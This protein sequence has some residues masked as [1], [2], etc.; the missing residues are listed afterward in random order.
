M[1]K[2]LGK[3][4]TAIC[5]LILIGVISCTSDEEITKDPASE[6]LVTEAK[7]F[8]N[9]NIVL[10]TH[11]TLNGVNKTLLK[12][13]CP[14]KFNFEWSETDDNTFTVSLLN[15]TVGKMGMIISFKCDVQTMQ[16]NT[17]EKDEY[18]GSGWFKFYGENGSTW[19]EDEGKSSSSKGSNVKGYYN[20][21]THEIN[22]IVDYNMMNVRSE[23]FLQTIDKGRINNYEEEFAQFEKDLAKYKEDHGL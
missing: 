22:F 15:F 7:K 11:A 20:V 19:S 14:T 23:C 1:K 17:W 10:N 16:L 13:G 4:I 12:S 21:Y 8:L 5:F 2:S 3:Y 6:E 9:G 18:K